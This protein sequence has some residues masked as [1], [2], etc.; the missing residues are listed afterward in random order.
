MNDIVWMIAMVVGY[1]MGSIPFGF[2]I[3]IV[4]GIDIR[5][6]GSCNI[7][8]TNCGRVVGRWWG[9]M[10]LVLDVCKGFLPVF[11]VGWWYGGF[12][13]V[14]VRVAESWRWIGVGVMAMVGHVFPV[15]LKFRGGKGVATGFGVVFGVWPFLTLP[16]FAGVL[17]W[18]LFASSLRYVGLASVVA[19][20]LLPYWLWL[21]ALVLRWPLDRVWPFYV[22]AFAMFV[23]IVIRHSGNLRRICQGR[24]PRLG[25]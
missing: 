12:G 6:E 9:I 25:E 16:A 21:I 10:C 14:E 18:L 22:A 24:E 13:G 3:G 4:H 8:A 20:M 11:A 7:G 15:W 1:F 5:K 17:T 19:S 23:L 2:L